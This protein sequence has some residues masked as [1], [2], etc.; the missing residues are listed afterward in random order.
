MVLKKKAYYK[1][2]NGYIKRLKDPDYLKFYELS[3]P[4]TTKRIFLF[5]PFNI[6]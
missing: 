5:Y 1:A 2:L 6:L 4:P 3:H